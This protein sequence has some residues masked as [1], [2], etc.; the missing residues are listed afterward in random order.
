MTSRTYLLSKRPCEVISCLSFL[1][2]F[3]QE[4]LFRSE[5]VP[6]LNVAGVSDKG[7]RDAV[8]QSSLLSSQRRRRS[9]NIDL[10]ALLLA[11][12]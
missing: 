8:T 7:G 12:S 3:V 11:P 5:I 10:N 1:S 2:V 9:G 6:V 4:R